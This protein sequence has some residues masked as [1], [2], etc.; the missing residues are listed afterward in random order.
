[1]IIFIFWNISILIFIWRSATEGYNKLCRSIHPSSV[2]IYWAVTIVMMLVNGTYMLYVIYVHAWHYNPQKLLQKCTIL[3]YCHSSSIY[4]HE[5]FAFSAKVTVVCITF[6]TELILAIR[7]IQ[8]T[9]ETG[10]PLPSQ[11]MK[12]YKL[13][14]CLQTVLLW[15]LFL[16]AQLL[17]GLVPI[18]FFALFAISPL[19]SIFFASSIAL[20]FMLTTAAIVPILRSC[21]MKC[22][23]ASCKHLGVWCLLYTIFIVLA[24][25]TIKLGFHFMAGGVGVHGAKAVVLSLL[26]SILL[27]AI[28][29]VIKRRFLNR[30]MSYIERQP[31]FRSISTEQEELD[32]DDME[33][34]VTLGRF[35]ADTDQEDIQQQH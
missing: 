31:S 33:Q 27:S 12:F 19:T 13:K 17:L 15:Q 7:V 25:A 22:M 4:R 34:D 8:N 1:L 2:P 3:P 23:C 30:K 26:P 10:L 20:L 21:Q 5:L 18:P 6:T 9:K 14:H 35:V 16:F 11:L 29:W 24:V 28:V 32:L